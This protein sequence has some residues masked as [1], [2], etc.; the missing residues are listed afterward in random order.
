MI[1]AGS[2]HSVFSPDL[3]RHALATSLSSSA[4]AHISSLLMCAA[5]VKRYF[6]TD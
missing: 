1:P 3:V 5:G 6:S 2:Y 4:A